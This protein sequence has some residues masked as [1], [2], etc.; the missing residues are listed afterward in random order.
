MSDD[1]GTSYIARSFTPKRAQWHSET[2]GD[3]LA[4]VDDASTTDPFDDKFDT[5]SVVEQMAKLGR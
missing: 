1:D 5:V 4:P 2:S 3:T